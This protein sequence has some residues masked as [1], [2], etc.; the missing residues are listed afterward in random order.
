M[1]QVALYNR[2]MQRGQLGKV[3]RT[4]DEAFAS[5]LERAAGPFLEH[6][7]PGKAEALYREGWPCVRQMSRAS[8][9]SYR[10]AA[11]EI[12]LRR[13]EPHV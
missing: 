11:Y 8:R 1:W 3:C 12:E 7:Y 2:H 5:A 4:R 6:P 9:R 13:I 10:D